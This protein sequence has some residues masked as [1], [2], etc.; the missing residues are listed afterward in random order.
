MWSFTIQ[1]V[2]GV[3]YIKSLQGPLGHIPLIPTGGVTLDNAAGFI[4]AGAIAVGLSS[5]L[6]PQDLLL[7]QDW[8]AITQRV[9]NLQKKL[10]NLQFL[11]N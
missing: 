3:N 9:S 1:A 6:F 8:N 4:Q 10:S 11:T 2:G 5:Q 7:A